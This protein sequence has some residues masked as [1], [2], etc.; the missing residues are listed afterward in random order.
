MNK[1]GDFTSVLCFDGH[2]ISSVSHCYNVFTQKLLK[3]CGVGHLVKLV[4]DL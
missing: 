1:T 3:M 2:N 4:A